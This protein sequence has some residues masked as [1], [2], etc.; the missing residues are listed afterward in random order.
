M[1]TPHTGQFGAWAAPAPGA[2]CPKD[3]EDRAVAFTCPPVTSALKAERKLPFSREPGVEAPFAVV[4]TAATKGQ[5]GAKEQ[6]I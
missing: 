5:L 6:K 3:R 1:C 2:K 4:A